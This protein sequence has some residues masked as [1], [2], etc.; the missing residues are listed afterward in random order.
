VYSFANVILNYPSMDAFPITSLEGAS[1]ECPVISCG[2]PAYA[3]TFAED[4]FRL[5]SPEDVSELSKAI[6][7]FVNRGWLGS[8]ERL[9]ELRRLVCRD[10][11]EKVASER[12]LSIYQKLL[13]PQ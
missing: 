4:Y 3:G 12:L 9:S 11:D 13:R 7:E 1:S 2:L 6:V 10:Y 8:R 5:V